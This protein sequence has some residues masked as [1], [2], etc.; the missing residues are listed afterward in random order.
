MVDQIKKFQKTTK[1]DYKFTLLIPTWNNLDYL[2]LCI[3]SIR[4]NSFYEIQIIVVV[5]E[6]TDGTLE[7]VAG[8]N[9]IDYIFSEKNIGICFALNSSRSLVKSEYIVYV[10]D[11]MYLLP[12]WDLELYKDISKIGTKSFMLSS[13][14]IEPYDT[15]NKSIV[16]KNYGTNTENFNES[17][18]LKE[19]ATLARDDWSGSSWPPN[20]VHVD[21]WDLVGGLSIEFS[22]GFGSDPDFARKLYEAE[23]RYFKGIGSSLVYHFGSKS[24]K[25]L[26]KNNG[27]N[28][29]L[30]KWGLT[31]STFNKKG[32]KRGE[33][34]N[35]D[36]KLPEL[37][38][39]DRLITKIKII[40]SYL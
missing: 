34:F 29:F 25:R 26:R 27:R 32:L 33:H 7:W 38:L 15:G 40:L 3:N 39:F 20:V 35:G 4:K 31:Q 2:Q 1:S 30:H 19:Y 5:N 37:S 12:N 21:I 17:L 6:G 10:N 11:D 9:E 28:M 8:Q 16:I 23:V 13:T 36:I 24:T 14:M 22:P 18:L